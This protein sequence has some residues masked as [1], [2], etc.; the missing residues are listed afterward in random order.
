MAS[1]HII[2]YLCL[3]NV[4]FP[5]QINNYGKIKINR[6]KFVGRNSKL[7]TN[8][9]ILKLYELYLKGIDSVKNIENMPIK[10]FSNYL[11]AYELALTVKQL[12][13]YIPQIEYF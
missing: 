13:D 6:F 1:N 9:E 11:N 10:K 2:D 8:G 4:I 7:Y 5:R 12:I 3:S